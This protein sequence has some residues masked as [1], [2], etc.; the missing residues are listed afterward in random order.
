M[1][2]FKNNTANKAGESIYG[3]Y[4]DSC[5][6]WSYKLPTRPAHVNPSDVTIYDAIFNF[7][8]GP[9]KSD[10]SSDPIGACFCDGILQNCA[11]K[12]KTVASFSGAHFKVESTA[13]AKSRNFAHE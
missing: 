8:N 7:T 1:F 3:G 4:F 2:E 11:N 13:S 6:P 10:I 5:N 9:G 12:L